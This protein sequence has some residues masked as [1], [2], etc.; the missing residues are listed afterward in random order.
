MVLH[1]RT[2]IETLE[3]RAKVESMYITFRVYNKLAND[4]IRPI[5]FPILLGLGC[6]LVLFVY[7]PLRHHELPGLIA[8]LL[9]ALAA[10]IMAIVFWLCFEAVTIIRNS[11]G[12]VQNLRTQPK[13]E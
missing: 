5:L 6:A 2:A 8:V 4:W 7:L 13:G 10:V 11:E 1:R 9:V 12:V 3:Q